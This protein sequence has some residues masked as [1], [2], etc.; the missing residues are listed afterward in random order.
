[1]PRS[2][3]ALVIALVTLTSLPASAQDAREAPDDTRADADVG[4]HPDEG[5]MIAGGSLFL[6]S[7]TMGV[8][9]L[10]PIQLSHCYDPGSAA[11]SRLPPDS[12]YASCGQAPLAAVP[13]AHLIGGGIDS[14]IGGPILLVA[15][16]V[17]LFMFIGGAA[18]HHPNTPASPRAGELTVAGV[19]GADVGLALAYHF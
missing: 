9:V 6:L 4:T 8:A 7:I 1:M 18:H 10:M 11:A 12:G 19:S 13:F 15:E 2:L 3:V 17:G 16:V 5:L 14:I